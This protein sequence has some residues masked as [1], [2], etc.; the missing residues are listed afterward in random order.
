MTDKE[1][2]YHQHLVIGVITFIEILGVTSYVLRLL[3]RRLSGTRLWYDDYVMGIGWCNW[4]FQLAWTATF[5]TVK[6]AV[7]ILYY[8]LFPGK[9]F[10]LVIYGIG[11]FLFLLLVGGLLGMLFQC[12]PM[13]SIWKPQIE[14]RCFNQMA[15]YIAGGS[16]NL[17]TDVVVVLTPIP[18]LWGLQLPRARRYG[19]VAV[20]LL[21]GL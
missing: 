8:R 21:A 10:R 15:F 20:F 4:I 3:A 6:I 14:H 13:E 12:I 7:L 16:L 19:L 5:P 17:V 1:V 11:A 2:L 9:T 18:I